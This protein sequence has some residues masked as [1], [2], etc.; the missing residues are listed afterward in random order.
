[1]DDTSTYTTGSGEEW[2]EEKLRKALE[3]MLNHQ[4][5]VPLIPQE[6]VNEK[7]KPKFQVQMFHG[8][9]VNDSLQVDEQDA[10]L[11]QEYEKL[12]VDVIAENL[13]LALAGD[14]DALM[15]KIRDRLLPEKGKDVIGD[16]LLG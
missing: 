4:P 7:P 9:R 10:K 3:Q 6:P 15:E 11:M 12:S 1:M 13:E 2:D 16:C 14:M 8:V 5:M